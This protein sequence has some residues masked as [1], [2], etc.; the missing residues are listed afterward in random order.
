MKEK[1]KHKMEKTS[2]EKVTLRNSDKLIVGYDLITY[3]ECK[4]GFKEPISQ[5]RHTH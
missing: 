4:C 2:T 5:E 1:H 3:K